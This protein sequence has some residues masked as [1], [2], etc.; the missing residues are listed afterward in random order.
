MDNLNKITD[1]IKTV[2]D[3]RKNKENSLELDNENE[4]ITLDN[5]PSVLL[6][7]ISS[8]LIFDDKIKF[9]QVNRLIFIGVRFNKL[10][11]Y[12]LSDTNFL[13]LVEYGKENDNIINKYISS[14]QIFNSLTIDQSTIMDWDEE[15]AWT[16]GLDR[17]EADLLYEFNYFE[18]FDYI[19]ALEI[20]MDYNWDLNIIWS[21]LFERRNLQNLKSLKIFGHYERYTNSMKHDPFRIYQLTDKITLEYIEI[22]GCLIDMQISGWRNWD[23]QFISSLKGFAINNMCGI[24]EEVNNVMTSVCKSF[25]NN[26]ESFHKGCNLKIPNT[27]NGKLNNLKEICYS[28]NSNTFEND[29]KILLNQNLNQLKRIYFGAFGLEI[30]KQLMEL[31]FSKIV[32]NVNYIG[33]S[34]E[35]TETIDNLCIQM[36]M[37]IKALENVRK[38]KLK[39]RIDNME[40]YKNQQKWLH[41]IETLII[42]LNKNCLNWMFIGNEW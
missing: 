12:H 6:S 1:I 41:K 16:T 13:D 38:N 4:N 18:L 3:S 40:C 35:Y 9:E 34:I 26:F 24:Q 8:Y 27:I 7:E 37:L 19:T 29:I 11:L 30:E 21:H 36:D 5:I 42:T 28:L 31:F 14:M 32:N 10:P 2:K 17:D 39:I 20:T 23:C 22:S 33:L 25:G 15:R